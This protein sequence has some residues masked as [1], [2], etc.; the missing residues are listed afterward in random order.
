[1]VAFLL[2]KD[3]DAAG[4]ITQECFLR[5][6]EKRSGFRGECSI[7]T[8]LLRI[9]VN[10]ARDYGKSRRMFFWKKLVSFDDSRDEA[11]SLPFPSQDLSP[12]QHLLVREELAAVWSATATL[13]PQQRSV[14]LL[15]FAE[16]MQLDEIAEVLQLKLGSVKVQLF[17]ATE[18]VRAALKEKS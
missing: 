18:K 17:R 6:Y 11:G 7:E 8:W 12:E 3:H 5:A 10:L 14:F 13:S 1:R 16:D 15:R 4:T 2:M 9:T